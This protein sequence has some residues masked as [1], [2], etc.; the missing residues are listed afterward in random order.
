MLSKWGGNGR[1]WWDAPCW[2]SCGHPVPSPLQW[3]GGVDHSHLGLVLKGTEHGNN[4]HLRATVLHVHFHSDV[5]LSF[6]NQYARNAF[7]SI[8]PACSPSLPCL[9]ASFVS[10]GVGCGKSWLYPSTEGHCPSPII[11]INTTLICSR[12]SSPLVLGP[13]DGSDPPLLLLLGYFLSIVITLHSVSAIANDL[14]TSVLWSLVG[15]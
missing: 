8:S 1:K 12:T 11:L 15:V 9:W 10:P 13:E 4:F 14:I 5:R 2:H 6:H 7:G 3:R